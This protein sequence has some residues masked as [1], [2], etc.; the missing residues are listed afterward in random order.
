MSVVSKGRH[1]E[2][3]TAGSFVSKV[4]IASLRGVLEDIFVLVSDGS[5]NVSE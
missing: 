4:H 5:S 3:L 2:R 1:G